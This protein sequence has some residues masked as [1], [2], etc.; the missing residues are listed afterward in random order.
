MQTK[1][2]YRLYTGESLVFLMLIWV[3]LLSS[4]EKEIKKG[5]EKVY[6]P[7]TNF[8]LEK[9]EQY[10]EITFDTTIGNTNCFLVENNKSIYFENGLTQSV[11]SEVLSFPDDLFYDLR[12]S[13]RS[14]YYT[15]EE[16]SLVKKRLINRPYIFRDNLGRVLKMEVRN[17][18]NGNCWYSYSYDKYGKQS[19]EIIK[20][21]FE[22]HMAIRISNDTIKLGDSLEVILFEQ[23]NNTEKITDFFLAISQRNGI[24]KRLTNKEYIAKK[25]RVFYRMRPESK[26][27]KHFKG[28]VNVKIKG[29]EEWNEW[30]IMPFDWVYIVI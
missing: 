20:S 23:Y 17:T 2:N 27:V 11:H 7:R 24:D 9:L 13:D 14:V 30:D 21:E 1:E 29:R 28:G 3:G 4:C 22:K 25:S 15:K 18:L 26:G 8:I 10:H 6:G 12:Y 5:I 16:G 19:K